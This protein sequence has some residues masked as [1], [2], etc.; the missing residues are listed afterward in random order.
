[1][2][3]LTPARVP[4]T[5]LVTAGGRLLDESYPGWWQYPRVDLMLLDMLQPHRCVLGQVSGGNWSCGLDRLFPD[6][7][8]TGQLLAAAHAGFWVDDR[9]P[10]DPGDDGED[11]LSA[12][13]VNRY[14]ELTVAW[15]AEI[16]RR[17]AG[18]N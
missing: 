14:A 12:E 10:F 11:V 15:R 6:L 3:T 5:M 4:V 13:T 2:E 18:Q 16:S 7:S 1:M 17:R 8:V 9:N